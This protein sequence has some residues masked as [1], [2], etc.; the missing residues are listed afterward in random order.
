MSMKK[1]IKTSIIATFALLFMFG[2][3]QAQKKAVRNAER[4]ANE[5][6]NLD[7]ALEEIKSAENDEKTKD[8]Y[9]TYYIKGLVYQAISKT[10]NEE[11]K[12]LSNYPLIDA[13]NCF[14]KAYNMDKS[15]PLHGTI[16][17]IFINLSNEL[18]NKA[19]EAYQN[20]NIK[21][22]NKYF[23]VTLDLKKHEIFGG[24]IDTAIIFNTAFTSQRIEDYD[25]AIEY[26]NKAISYGYNGG[27]TYAYLAE[28]YKLKGDQENYVKTLKTGFEK[29]PESQGLL[30]SIINYYLLEAED[31]DEAFKYLALARENDP[32]N[33]QFY[34][35]EAHLYDKMGDKETAKEKYAKAIEL[36]PN[37]FEGYYNLGVLYF[38]E[39]VSLTDEAN[40][41]TDNE[42]YAVAKE[43]ADAKFLESLPY[44][45][46]AHELQPEDQAIMSTLKTLY[47]RLKANNPELESK[48]E[49]IS[50]KME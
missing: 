10:E 13:Y 37:F 19:I 17:M 31:S 42:K 49:E 22:A 4:M 30:G 6:T 48:Y 40:K 16:D 18:V 9:R 5:G 26:Y 38:N 39:G 3:V 11:Y 32:T 7:Q 27:D 21:D 41:I 46:K 36:D 24:E 45:E 20:E 12:S 34:S 35:A 15:K 1:L 43:K 2:T 8:W 29:Y 44:I 14:N 28:T 50:K 47:Y 25:K 33:P 23:E